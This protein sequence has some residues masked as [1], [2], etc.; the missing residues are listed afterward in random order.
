MSGPKVL[1]SWGRRSS[2][3]EEKF[4]CS[5]HPKTAR[6]A[7]P[8]ADG[9][10]H[11]V[12]IP[13]GGAMK[14]RNPFSPVRTKHPGVYYILG[15][16]P[17]GKPR[18][19]FYVQYYR[20]GKRHF[21]KV[22]HE[23]EKLNG[24]TMSAAVANRYAPTGYAGRNSRTGSGARRSGQRKRLTMHGGRSRNLRRNTS[25]IGSG[26]KTSRRTGTSTSDTSRTTSRIRPPRKWT[27]SPWTV[28]RENSRS[29]NPRR[30]RKGP[31]PLSVSGTRWRCSGRS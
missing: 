22:G 17:L 29:G 6:G 15:T 18:R 4:P 14:K 30:A 24:E 16:D 31:S 28:S 10:A 20:G 21:E 2:F 23:G 12:L 26:K 1:T 3:E 25:R 9:S 7:N 5:P 19:T 8:L 13:R 11:T 27:R